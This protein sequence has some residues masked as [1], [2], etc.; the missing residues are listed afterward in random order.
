MYEHATKLLNDIEQVQELDSTRTIR[1]SQLMPLLESAKSLVHKIH[2]QPDALQADVTVSLKSKIGNRDANYLPT[3]VLSNIISFFKYPKT[4]QPDLHSCCLVSRSWYSVA[5]ALLY[6]AP[7]FKRGNSLLFVKRVFPSKRVQNVKRPLLEYI[8]TLDLR[9]WREGK[10]V[11]E[12]LL[13]RVHGGLEVFV[14]P[15]AFA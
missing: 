9:Y 5:I 1:L 7:V 14:A 3:E 13:G 8:E 12:R 15:R 11:T 4:S 6:Q 10:S 2:R